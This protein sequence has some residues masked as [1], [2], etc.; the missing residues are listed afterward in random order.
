[1]DVSRKIAAELFEDVA[2]RVLAADNFPAKRTI[3]DYRR[4]IFRSSGSCS[5]T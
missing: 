1:M 5:C 2:F 4:G 3:V